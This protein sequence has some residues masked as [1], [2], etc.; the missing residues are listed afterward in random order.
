MKR[1][2]LIYPALILALSLAACG[3]SSGGGSSA[4]TPPTEPPTSAAPAQVPES[5]QNPVVKEEVPESSQPAEQ[6]A[7]ILIAYFTVPEEVDTSGVDA[8]AGAS[9][10]VKDEE[11]LGNTEYVAK[12]VQETV[13]G[14]LFRI[15]TTEQYPLIHE[16]LVD[17]AADE[18]GEDARPE[19]ASH[20]EDI[21]Q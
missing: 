16:V 18:Q 9:I 14:D 21:D 10:V 1:K 19:L 2:I 13:G 20:V 12:L 15:E 3:Q 11:I 6:D 5:T 8:V 4:P 17:Q 7:R